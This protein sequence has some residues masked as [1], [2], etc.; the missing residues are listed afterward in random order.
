MGKDRTWMEPQV[1]GGM[2]HMIGKG[3]IPL[4]QVAIWD[5]RKAVVAQGAPNVDRGWWRPESSERT[6]PT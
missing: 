3:E 6:L 1:Q 2:T 5:W 4:R